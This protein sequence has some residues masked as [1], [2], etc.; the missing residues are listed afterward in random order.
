MVTVLPPLPRPERV[1]A[2]LGRAG[3]VVR[4]TVPPLYRERLRRERREPARCERLG[5][6]E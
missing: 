4:T 1:L 3:T 6:G 2:P 5:G